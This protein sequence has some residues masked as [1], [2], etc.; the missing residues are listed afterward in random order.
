MGNATASYIPSTKIE[1]TITYI[2]ARENQRGDY[3]MWSEYSQ[4][5]CINYFDV[6][7]DH[8]TM[9]KAENALRVAQMIVELI[10]PD[11]VIPKK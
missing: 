8:F 3:T 2:K 5:N 4:N 1:T 11:K 6:K 9:I 10:I 7:G